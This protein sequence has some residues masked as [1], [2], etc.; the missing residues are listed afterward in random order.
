MESKAFSQS[1]AV[2]LTIAGSDSGA[3]AGIQADLKAFSEN[4]AFSSFVIRCTTAQNPDGVAPIHQIPPESVVSQIEQVV[5]FCKPRSIKAGMLYSTPII[6]AVSES[7]DQ[8]KS[9]ATIVVDP[10]MIATS[11]KTLVERRW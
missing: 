6:N 2:A 1:A 4:G 10:V 5:T 9:T 3:N 11:G 7:L 8:L